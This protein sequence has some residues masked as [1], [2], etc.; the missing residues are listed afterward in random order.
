[1]D[2]DAVGHLHLTVVGETWEG[3][4]EPVEALAR[5][6]HPDRVTVVNRYVHD[7]EVAT[8]FAEADV[9]VLPY[10]RSSA[11]GP[12][13]IAMAHGLPVVLTDVGGLRDGAGSYEGITWVAPSDVSALADALRLAPSLKGRRYR[14]ERSWCD[15][16][17]AYDG[18]FAEL[19]C[20]S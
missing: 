17:R 10:T 3:W 5:S 13:H 4:H 8:F 16:V 6:R 11:S 18:L 1:L 2:D 7:D 15:N 19:A 14:D 9:V 12:L 20:A